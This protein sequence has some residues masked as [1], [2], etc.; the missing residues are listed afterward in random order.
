MVRG[1]W[2]KMEWREKCMDSDY[3]ATSDNYHLPRKNA[4]YRFVIWN[5]QLWGER[6]QMAVIGERLGTGGNGREPS[7]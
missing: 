4:S 3:L 5:G 7:G 2:G 6:F 1:Q